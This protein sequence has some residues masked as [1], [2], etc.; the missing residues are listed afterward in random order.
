[1]P[2]AD[3][4]LEGGGVKGLGLVG[5]VLALMDKGYTFQRVAGTSAGSI[6][7]AFL[8]AGA[9][10]EQLAGI[11]GRLD[12]ARVPDRSAPAV[13][14]LSEG[15]GLL[16]R[17]G[18]HPGQYI[19]DFVAEELEAL[20]VR[21]FGDLRRRD[22]K[23]DPS[24]APYQAYNLVV[25]ATDITRGRLLRLPWDYHRLNLEADEQLVA[26]AV[27]ASISI[28]LFFAPVTLRDGTTGAKY[29][30]V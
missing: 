2:N 7:A 17:S 22:P 3:L 8:A 4:V 30:L 15:I 23:A 24:L 29:T 14:G 16:H 18:A 10:A 1:M 11:M 28:P 19:R 21:T 6:V 27:R 5:A 25:T 9:T 20:G 13:P 12:Y 26:D